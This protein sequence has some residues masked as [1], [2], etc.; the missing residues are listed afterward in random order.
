MP[1]IM[2]YELIRKS[3]PETISKEQLYKLCH[4]SKR[5]AKYYLDNG[6]IPCVN[7]GHATYKYR[8]RTEDV[9]EF[10][11]KRDRN[12]DAYSQK[13]TQ[14]LRHSTR[15]REMTQHELMQ[16]QKRVSALMNSYPDLM[17]VDM[18]AQ[19]TGYTKK[20]VFEWIAAGKLRAFTRKRKYY[21]PKEYMTGFMLSESFL[22][23]SS[24][25]EQHYQMMNQKVCKEE[26]DQDH[27]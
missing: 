27:D 25:C 1:K 20:T 13:D 3:Y 23:I 24:K 22:H 10:M 15:K 8:I 14:A 16:Y 18:I 7:T 4:I 19:V 26:G 6:T 2:N 17:T 9:I 12:P 21:I 11:R 5:V